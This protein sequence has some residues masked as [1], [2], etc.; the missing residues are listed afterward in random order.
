[1]RKISLFIVLMLVLASVVGCGAQNEVKEE[2]KNEGPTELVISTWG[3]SEDLLWEN[4]FKPFEEAN[5]V[6]IVLE[7]GNNSDRLTKLKTNP[8]SNIDIMYLAEAFAQQGA[9]EGLFE[10]IDYSKIPNAKKIIEK[11]QYLVEQGYG[12][13][14]TLNRAAIAYDPTKV[15]FE[16]KSWKDLWNPA[17]KGKV[18]IPEITTTFGPSTMYIASNKAGVDITSDKGE[19][20]FN[21]LE[22]LKPNLV[23]TYTKSSDLSNMFANG[24]IA[25]AITADFAYGSVKNGA[26]D[27][28]FVDPEEGAYLNFNT[29]NIVKGSENVELALKFIDYAL[30]T[31]VQT[32]TAKALNES[33][34]NKEVELTAEEAESLTY[35]EKIETANVVDHKFVN[36]VNMEWI[37]KWNRILNQ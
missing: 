19:A 18:S 27:V 3:F 24:E 12:P 6:K 21:E 26:P 15:D 13:G 16:I 22:A 14:Y 28:V 34:V 32:R 20:A 2:A 11:G 5:N 33:P 36:S 31:E 29:I 7:T 1:M 25:A 23:K 37:D 9:E 4:V 30:S 10:K 8:N 17:L 35:G